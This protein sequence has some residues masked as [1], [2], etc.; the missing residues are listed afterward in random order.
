MVWLWYWML[1]TYLNLLHRVSFNNKKNPH[2]YLNRQDQMHWIGPC[3]SP[4][5]GCTSSCLS[6]IL[7]LSLL[8][9]SLGDTG[10]RTCEQIPLVFRAWLE[11][12]ELRTSFKSQKF[13]NHSF[14]L[15]DHHNCATSKSWKCLYLT[16]YLL[17]VCYVYLNN[18]F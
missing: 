15:N 16:Q 18:N 9:R 4:V 7:L 12:K 5:T 14:Y 10:D 6:V 13:S 8:F 2:A 17:T 11:E 3:H 1:L